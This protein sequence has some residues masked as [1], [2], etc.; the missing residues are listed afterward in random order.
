MRSAK[1]LS[2]AIAACL[3]AACAW[4]T[5]PS[6]AG[7]SPLVV[8]SCPELSPLQPSPDGTV[9]MGEVVDKLRDVASTYRECRAAAL[10]RP[11]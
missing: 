7:P 6:P 4:P 9:S 3:Q 11:P 2:I 10:A 5:K 1:T 8:A